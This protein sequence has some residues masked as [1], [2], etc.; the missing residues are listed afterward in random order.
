MNAPSGL[1]GR[2]LSLFGSKVAA[3][4]LAVLTTPIIVRLLGAGA[5]GDYAV[6]LSIYSL[7]MI[8]ISAAVAEGVQKFV[9]E[10]R[11]DGWVERV[12]Q[13]YFVL[14]LGLALLGSAVLIVAT[15]LGAGRLLGEGFSG[16]LYV[17]AAFILVGQFRA[18]STHTLLGFSLEYVSGPLDVL[19]KAT[20]VTVGIALVLGGLSVVGMLIGHVVANAL[21][22]VIAASVVLRRVSVRRLVTVPRS[23][24]IRELLSFNLLNVAVVFLVMSLF[25]IDVIMVRTLVGDD[26]TGY[27]KAALALA[28][29]L[30]IVPI[31]LQQ[32]LIHSTSRLWSEQR[33]AAITDLASRIT[34]YTAL[35]VGLMAI[36]LAVLADRVVVLYY[37]GPFIVAATPLI[38]LLPG[39]VGFAIARPLQAICQGSGQLRALVLAVGTTA[40]LNV[41]L[42]GM[43][44]VPFGIL[45]AATATSVA[46]GS[47]V[48]ALVWTSRRIG[49]DPLSDLR[50]PRIGA[51]VLIT[52]IVI[53]AI[54]SVL[55]RD[56]VALSIVPPT[57]AAVFGATALATGALDRAE[58]RDLAERSP[59]NWPV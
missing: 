35:L 6:V 45:G 55:V 29:Y 50:L 52:G 32:L 5:Y 24:P 49:F 43:L 16:Y 26:A 53:V 38:V 20:T 42:N 15:H 40:V 25:H 18:L 11:D 39:A 21:V 54:E 57:G 14:G 7:Y 46:Y 13:V 36:G 56:I 17:L 28:E 30:W 10:S 59:L 22:A 23:V 58:L 2:F 47:M 27:Y 19:K 4:V 44:I 34:R 3:T 1:I 8:P 48:V 9:A 51:T 37:G 12:L 33:H 31:V 41:V